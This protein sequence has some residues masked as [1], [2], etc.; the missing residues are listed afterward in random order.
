VA[1]T[2]DDEVKMP[3]DPITKEITVGLTTEMGN[4]LDALCTAKRTKASIY[5]REAVYDR[6]VRDGFLVHPMANGAPQFRVTN[7]HQ[8]QI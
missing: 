8:E 5:C 2:V 3:A 4:A 1:W 6:L 7:A